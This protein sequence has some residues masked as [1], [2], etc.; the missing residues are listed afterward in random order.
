MI[1]FQLC[2]R[3]IMPLSWFSGKESACQ[4]R[5]GQR[6]SF[7]PCVGNIPGSRKWQPAPAFLPGKFHRQRSLVGYSPSQLKPETSERLSAHVGRQ[8]MP[9]YFKGWQIM[10]H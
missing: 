6:F 9:L 5:G 2:L 3:M 7:N 1:Y 8:H 4:F 10:A